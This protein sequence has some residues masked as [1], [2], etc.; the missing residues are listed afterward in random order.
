MDSN[1]KETYLKILEEVKKEMPNLILPSMGMFNEEVSIE[2]DSSKFI[3]GNK[4]D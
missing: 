1:E 4:E 2:M 3:S